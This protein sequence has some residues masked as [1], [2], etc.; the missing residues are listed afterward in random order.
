M[1]GM[2]LHFHVV[3]PGGQLHLRGLPPVRL[4]R[5]LR[6][7]W[8]A[9]RSPIGEIIRETIKPATSVHWRKKRGGQL[10]RW[11]TALKEDLAHISGPPVYGIW[12]LWQS[13]SPGRR[14]AELWQRQFGTWVL[15]LMPAQPLPGECRK[16]LLWTSS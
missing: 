5:R 1:D 15:L 14:I 8:H 11:I 2:L 7:F 9:A 12:Y 13:G 6:W 16:A 4:Q 10:K 3:H